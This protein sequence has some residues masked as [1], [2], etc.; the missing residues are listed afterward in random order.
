MVTFIFI[1]FFLTLIFVMYR[2]ESQLDK[3]VMAE[4]VIDIHSH[5]RYLIREEAMAIAEKYPVLSMV[6]LSFADTE[7]S[8]TSKETMENAKPIDRT[9]KEKLKSELKTILDKED[10][11]AEKVAN[12]YI[13]ACVIVKSNKSKE[14]LAEISDKSRMIS[15]SQYDKV[16]SE[17]L[18]IA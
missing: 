8:F 16:V 6:A 12:W 9:L 18:C 13:M 17:D 2:R 10:V 4:A 3:E 14:S 5:E 1:S 7:V 11:S 15:K